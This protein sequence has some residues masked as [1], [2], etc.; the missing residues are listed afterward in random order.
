MPAI[1][2][3]LYPPRHEIAQ[4]NVPKR[5]IYLSLLRATYRRLQ[6]KM[7]SNGGPTEKDSKK[8]NGNGH[9]A[10]G[11]PHW[12]YFLLTAIVTTVSCAVAVLVLPYYLQ[13]DYGL[14]AAVRLPGISSTEIRL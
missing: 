7:D 12:S 9:R 6:I 3:F 14:S 1:T 4:L 10:S 2:K 5:I 8:E 11:C 13:D